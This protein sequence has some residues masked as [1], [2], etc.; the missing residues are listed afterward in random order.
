MDVVH[1]C[2]TNNLLKRFLPVN[3]QRSPNVAV[4]FGFLQRYANVYARNFETFR[5]NVMRMLFMNVSLT[6]Y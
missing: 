6:V 1:E 5:D 4:W 3:I 2:F